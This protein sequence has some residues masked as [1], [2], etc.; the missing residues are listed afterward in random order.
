MELIIGALIIAVFFTALIS[1]LQGEKA[2]AGLTFFFL[3]FFLPLWALALWVPAVGPVWYG[4]AW[5]DL[6]VFAVVLGLLLLSASPRGNYRNQLMETRN[7]SEND[8]HVTAMRRYSAAFWAFIALMIG[9]ILFGSTRTGFAK[10]DKLKAG[11]QQRQEQEVEPAVIVTTVAVARGTGCWATL[12]DK[13]H[14]QGDKITLFDG[15]DLPEMKFS[16]GENWRG[17]VESLQVGPKAELTLFGEPFWT[18]QD[19]IVK[20]GAQVAIMSNLPWD[21]VES[22]KLRCTR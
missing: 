20:P 9:A 11:S 6:M 17:R 22:L 14:F 21:Y 5:L 15:V 4:I 18:D 7:P 12:Y 8:Q 1:L 2:W 3:L 13:N 19:Y 16:D 10:A